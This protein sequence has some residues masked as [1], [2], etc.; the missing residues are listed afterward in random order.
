MYELMPAK[1]VLDKFWEG[2]NW[3]EKI[4]S[5]FE[6]IVYPASYKKDVDGN[7]IYEFDMPGVGPEDLSITIEDNHSIKI[8]AKVGKREYS[9]EVDVGEIDPDKVKAKMDKGI[10][11][12]TI[13]KADKPAEPKKIEVE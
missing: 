10:L 4:E 12:L 3:F 2:G 7:L 11:T 6:K 8:E 1:K 13:Q 5:V 9:H